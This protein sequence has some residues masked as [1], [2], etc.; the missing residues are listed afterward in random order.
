MTPQNEVNLEVAMGRVEEQ[1]KSISSIVN[2]IKA[3]M[4]RDSE[5][6][7]T[8]LDGLEKK[9]WVLWGGAVLAFGVAMAWLKSKIGG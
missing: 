5:R 9:V 3:D 6:T 1:L 8:R 7:D 2:E 4:R